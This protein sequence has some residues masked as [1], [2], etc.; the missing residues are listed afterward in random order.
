M[1]TGDENIVDVNFTV[2]WVIKDPAK[3]LFDVDN[4]EQINN[5]VAESAMREVVGQTQI[6]PIMTGYRAPIRNACANEFRAEGSEIKQRIEGRAERE[7]TVLIAE[8]NREAQILR[9]KGEVEQTRILG[10]ALGQDPDFFA[11][12]R[13]MQAY[14]DALPA[15]TTRVLLSPDSEFFRCFGQTPVNGSRVSPSHRRH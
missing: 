2:G 9:G 15:D 11:F 4:P 5:A 1:L 10:D 14:R 3:Y 8:A 13:S 6:G 12:Y 7:R